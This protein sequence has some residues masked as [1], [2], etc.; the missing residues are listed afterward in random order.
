MSEPHTHHTQIQSRTSDC[1]NFEVPTLVGT[2]RM[3]WRQ[4]HALHW[5]QRGGW[6]K[7][8]AA[9]LNVQLRLAQVLVLASYSS[10]NNSNI[11][12]P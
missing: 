11:S 10:K 5:A 6:R 12:T 2:F 1:G 9:L 8:H 3:G 4:R 7:R